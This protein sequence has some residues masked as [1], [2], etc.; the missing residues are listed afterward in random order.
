[1]K[2]HKELILRCN[3]H[4]I[5]SQNTRHCPEFYQYQHERQPFSVTGT[6]R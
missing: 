3:I 2:L 1:M 5:Q 6:W 4:S